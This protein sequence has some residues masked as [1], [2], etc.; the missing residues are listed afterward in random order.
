MWGFIIALISG[1]LMSVQEGRYIVLDFQSDGS[2][3]ILDYNLS[4]TEFQEKYE[5]IK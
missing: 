3:S 1:A 5:I 2:I 4:P